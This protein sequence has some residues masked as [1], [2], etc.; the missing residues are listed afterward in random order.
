MDITVARVEA[1]D[2]DRGDFERAKAHY[3]RSIDLFDFLGNDT[4]KNFV[5]EEYNNFL[6]RFLG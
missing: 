5:L 3:K 6:N 2:R 4:M 1:S